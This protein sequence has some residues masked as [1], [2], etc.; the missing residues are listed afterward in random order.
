MHSPGVIG[1]LIQL[2]WLA[3]VVTGLLELAGLRAE[4]RAAE[5]ALLTLMHLE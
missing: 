3:A 5:V 1:R 2:L 4:V